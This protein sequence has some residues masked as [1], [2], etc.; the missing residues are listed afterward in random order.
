MPKN[1]SQLNHLFSKGCFIFIC[2][3]FCA[4]L[5]S[6][7]G[8]NSGDNTEPQINQNE[9]KSPSQEIVNKQ[10]LEQL[11][12][13]RE[14]TSELRGK[15]EELQTR[16]T[17]QKITNIPAQT[18]PKP[19]PTPVNSLIT[20]RPEVVEFPIN[21]AAAIGNLDRVKELVDSGVDINKIT[22]DSTPL[23]QAI[24]NGRMEIAEYLINKGADVNKKNTSGLLP[25]QLAQAYGRTSLEKLLIK[26]GAKQISLNEIVNN[27]TPPEN[28][29][30]F[31]D[32][33]INYLAYEAITKG[34]TNKLKDLID[35]GLKV[36]MRFEKR[37]IADSRYPEGMLPVAVALQ[38]ANIESFNFLLK[39]KANIV[40]D[41]SKGDMPLIHCISEIIKNKHD[42]NLE[43]TTKFHRFFTKLLTAKPD[44]ANK[45]ANDSAPLFYA[46]NHSDEELVSELLD[47]G[48]D[49]NIQDDRGLTPLHVALMAQ[50]HSHG[51]EHEEH[52]HQEEIGILLIKRGAKIDIL[53]NNGE[54]AL[55]LACAGGYLNLVKKMF[56]KGAS[57]NTSD[58][59]GVT[60]LSATLM[61]SAIIE[62]TSRHEQIAK[63]LVESGANLMVKDLN[64][65][66]IL[67]MAVRLENDE[68]SILFVNKHKDLGENE[69]GSRL[70]VSAS[71]SGSLKV[72]EALIEKGV[73]VNSVDDKG[74][75]ALHAA[76]KA[77]RLKLCS[78][79]INS[80][81]DINARLTEG[82][83]A[84]DTPLDFAYSGRNDDKINVL[85]L[86]K[87][88]GA[89]SGRN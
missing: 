55:I 2:L 69:L 80:G 61:A 81:S 76:A 71:A 48:A 11:T 5:A 25:I 30:E 78:F 52:G 63:L 64:G 75:T 59:S 58:S 34:D 85:Q 8:S 6:G 56:E 82:P 62:D 47:A 72:A 13:L 79:L 53:G 45:K 43:K 67:E 39:N 86:L 83:F 77:G 10:I 9:T 15:M 29:S 70:L 16:N 38:S 22:D 74:Q 46:A 44:L 40:H 50:N 12:K 65:Q 32:L 88:A 23:H 42:G 24:E 21:T 31:V 7:C 87:S 35:K 41:P 17:E 54:N 20:H 37:I 4:I 84:G 26:A 27:N 68:L 33:D 51:I 19:I 49:P 66:S 18:V 73:S 36:N 89:K 1:N 3:I 14:E 28:K 57:P 60:P